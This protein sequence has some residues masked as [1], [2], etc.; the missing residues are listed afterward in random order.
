[1]KLKIESDGTTRG[2]RV[3]N[4]ATGE[5]LEDVREVTWEWERGYPA[6]V[7]ITVG[8][9]GVETDLSLL[10]DGRVLGVR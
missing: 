1:M 4:A 3:I 8:G 9:G 6:N 7:R 10:V 2:T 5:E